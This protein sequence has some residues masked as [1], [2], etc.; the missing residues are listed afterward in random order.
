MKLGW[1][2]YIMCE[3]G[4]DWYTDDFL[5]ADHFSFFLNCVSRPDRISHCKLPNYGLKLM[6][7]RFWAL[8][9][10]YTLPKYSFGRFWTQEL[11]YHG[12]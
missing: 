2:L 9:I 8:G 11:A 4:T 7:E 1:T 6:S 5:L 10:L 3:F 12:I